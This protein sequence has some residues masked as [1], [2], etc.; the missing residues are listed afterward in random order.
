MPLSTG[1]QR[2]RWSYHGRP[3]HALRDQAT[4][5]PLVACTHTTPW[6]PDL[7]LPSYKARTLKKPGPDRGGPDSL[8]SHASWPRIA[9]LPVH[10]VVRGVVDVEPRQDVVVSCADIAA[11]S[12][13]LSERRL[14]TRRCFWGMSG[15]IIP[16]A[17]KQFAA[18]TRKDSIALD[19]WSAIDVDHEVGE[20]SHAAEQGKDVSDGGLGVRTLRLFPQPPTK[21]REIG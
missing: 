5:R 11:Q 1:H 19:I 18:K 8:E 16:R 21:T 14:R 4:W 15:E 17:L 7:Y 2:P 10:S 12:C 9:A 13:Q 20:R 6:I 3:S